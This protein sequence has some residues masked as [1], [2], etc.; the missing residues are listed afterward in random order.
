MQGQ[1][2]VRKY[3]EPAVKVFSDFVTGEDVLFHW[4]SNMCIVSKTKNNMLYC[5]DCKD[6]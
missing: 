1:C 3:S 4:V 2:R 6:V 5:N